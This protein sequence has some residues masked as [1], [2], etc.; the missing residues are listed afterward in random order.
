MA[1]ILDLEDEGRARAISYRAEKIDVLS[2]LA[3]T[4]TPCAGNDPLCPCADG[5]SCHYKDAGKTKAW[6]VPEQA[7]PAR[8]IGVDQ[9]EEKA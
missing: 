7:Q 8:K 6:P 9:V 2:A 4:P 3:E 5:D 1:I